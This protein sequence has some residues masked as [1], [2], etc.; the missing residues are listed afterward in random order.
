MISHKHKCIFIHIPKN[1]GSSVE[2]AFGFSDVYHQGTS[3][4]S[5]VWQLLGFWSER[6][7]RK[8]YP[9]D[10]NSLWEDNKDYHNQAY[11]THFDEYHKFAIVRNP[12]DRLVSTWKYDKKLLTMSY[13]ELVANEESESSIKW[14]ENRRDYHKEF[15]K[16]A[17]EGFR[18]F[19]MNMSELWDKMPVKRPWFNLDPKKYPDGVFRY[20]PIKWHQHSQMTFLVDADNNMRMDHI[21]RFENLN[22]D[23]CNFCKKVGLDL[24]LPHVNKSPGKHYTEY[25]D[26]ETRE[27]VAKRYAKDIE[28]FNYEFGE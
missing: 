9:L 1:A 12:W 20:R 16:E 4:H 28:Y 11:A 27:I 14:L 24:E 2:K 13:E 10:K 5:P 26:D 7:N 18:D 19:V 25:Y 8:E 22:E 23:W 3:R 17:G 21:L 15:V 6:V